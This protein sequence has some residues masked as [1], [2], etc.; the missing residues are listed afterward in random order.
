MQIRGGEEDF[1]FCNE[2]GEQASCRTYQQ[3]VRRYNRKRNVE[4]TSCHCFRHTFAKKT[5]FL[6]VAIGYVYKRYSVIVI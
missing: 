2:Y 5:G 1:V 4:K 6:T 3:L